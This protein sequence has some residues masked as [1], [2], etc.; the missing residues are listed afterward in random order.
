MRDELLAVTPDIIGSYIK[1][2]VYGSKDA[3]TDV[4][5][6]LYYW[7]STIKKMI[8]AMQKMEAARLGR[9]SQARRAFWSTEYMQV[10]KS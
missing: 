9:P 5:T 2:K 1:M 10:W 4:Q 8:K 7:S 3:Q 6:P